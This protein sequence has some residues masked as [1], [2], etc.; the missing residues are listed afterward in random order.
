MDANLV[1][2]WLTLAANIGVIA[3]IIFLA[4]ELRQNS[5]LMRAESRTAMA[6]DLISLMTMN[7]NDTSY[8]DTI[9]R[10]LLGEELTE[11]EQ[12]QF[13]RT[14]TAWIWHWNNLAYLHRV[15]LYDDAE[16]ALQIESIRA[17]MDGLPG[18]KK[19]WCDNSRGAVN[20]ELIEAIEGTS[21]GNFCTP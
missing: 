14:Q 12:E 8:V 19:H 13:Y 17:E 18:M 1:N 2:K 3:G 5:E 15:G 9:Y 10:G 20:P 16:Y 4:L 21:G 6:Q 11:L 7:I